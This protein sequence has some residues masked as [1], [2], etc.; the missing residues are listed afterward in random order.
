MG[1]SLRLALAEQQKEL[2][3]DLT[4]SLSFSTRSRLFTYF[5]VLSQIIPLSSVEPRPLIPLLGLSARRSCR[6][7]IQILFQRIEIYRVCLRTE[8]GSGKVVFYIK[9]RFT[10]IH[11]RN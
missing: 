1:S 3:G 9:Y 2:N 6:I 5:Q 10:G 7:E 11:E 4:P 8:F